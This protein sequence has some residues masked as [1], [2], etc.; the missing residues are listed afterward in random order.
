MKTALVFVATLDGKVTKWGDPLVRK[1]SSK[2]DKDYFRMIWQGSTLIVMG[3][4]TFNAHR[5]K[6]SASHYFVVMTSDPAKYKEFEVT[7]Q[8][9]FSDES[10]AQLS[11][12]LDLLD[13]KYMLLIGGPHIATSFLKEQLVD[14]L[15]LTIEPRIFGTGGNFA[16]EDELDIEL[17]LISCEKVNE[18]GTLITKYALLKK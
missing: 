14:E 12:R 17:S 1:W 4:T 15:W 8:L 9:E 16:I 18:R 10:P 6:P 3:S 2:A 5:V 11:A 7:G 13:Y